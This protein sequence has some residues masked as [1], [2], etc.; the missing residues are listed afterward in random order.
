M[1]NLILILFFNFNVYKFSD[2]GNLSNFLFVFNRMSHS[3]RL[4]TF[5]FFNI[6]ILKLHYISWSFTEFY[7]SFYY[8]FYCSFYCGFY[9]PLF[10]YS[11]CSYDFKSSICV[12]NTFKYTLKNICFAD[13]HTSSLSFWNTYAVCSSLSVVFFCVYFV[14]L[15]HSVDLQ[16]ES[17]K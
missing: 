2:I 16:M 10:F 6:Y 5:Y 17:W 1:F 4:L 3:L 12:F 8:G 9:Y 14:I 13:C 11:S 15:D 7:C